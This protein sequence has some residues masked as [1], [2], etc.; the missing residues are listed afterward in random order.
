MGSGDAYNLLGCIEYKG[1][2]VPRDYGQALK[3][4]QE[5]ERLDNPAALNNLAWLCQHGYGVPMHLAKAVE[6]YTRSAEAGYS[7]AQCNLGYLYS[8]GLGVEKNPA[9][10]CELFQRSAAAGNPT[11][12]FNLALLHLDREQ[13]YYDADRAGALLRKCALAGIAEAR[14]L[15]E[16]L[17]PEQIPHA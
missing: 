8:Q 3:Y 4:F 5:A 1:Y 13:N 12:M 6:Y 17:Q 10:A 16:Q 2:K 9:L 11:A 14:P 15:L 7:S